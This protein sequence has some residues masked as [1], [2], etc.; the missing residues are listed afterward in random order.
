[1]KFYNSTNILEVT[2]YGIVEE[3]K[4]QISLYVW[5]DDATKRNGSYK[6]SEANASE[7]TEDIEE[8][9]SRYWQ[10][11]PDQTRIGTLQDSWSYAKNNGWLIPWNP[12]SDLNLC[13]L[14][15]KLITI[16][17]YIHKYILQ[18]E[19]KILLPYDKRP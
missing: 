12:I 14:I 4:L 5:S 1:M 7:F 17:F 3:L 6:N 13:N 9:V 10:W 8:S 11:S 18:F 15:N 19:K 16:L 2:K